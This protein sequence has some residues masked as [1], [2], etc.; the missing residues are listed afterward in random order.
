MISSPRSD[1]NGLPSYSALPALSIDQTYVSTTIPALL[2]TVTELSRI[3]TNG[4]TN[5]GVRTCISNNSNVVWDNASQLF[6]VKTLG[7]LDVAGVYSVSL[8]CSLTNYPTV[9]AQSSAFL[10]TVINC[11]GATM[12][13]PTF[14]ALSIS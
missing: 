8:T 11:S 5:C 1:S 7:A 13:A 12:T 4:V 9:A 3:Y 2:D 10:L 14:P 6:T